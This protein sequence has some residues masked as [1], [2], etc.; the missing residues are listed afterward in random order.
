MQVVCYKT[1]IFGGIILPIIIYFLIPKDSS[2]SIHVHSHQRSHFYHN[3]QGLMSNQ[4]LPLSPKAY[5]ERLWVWLTWE[6]ILFLLKLWLAKWLTWRKS[7]P[8]KL[9]FSSYDPW[10]KERVTLWNKESCFLFPNHIFL[11]VVVTV[12]TVLGWGGEK[13]NKEGMAAPKL[14]GD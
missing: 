12:S 5:R 3:T 4:T 13:R 1:D 7:W 11:T 10:W 8:C 2:I 6:Q 14:W 9:D